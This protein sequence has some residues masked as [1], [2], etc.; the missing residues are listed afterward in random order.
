MIVAVIP[1]KRHSNRLA[2]KNL[3]EIDELPL[4]THAIRY[5]GRFKSVNKIVVSTDSEKVAEIAR[6]NGAMIHLRGQELSGE[7]PLI[8]VYR[9]VAREI[10]F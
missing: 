1:A 8:E 2:D 4:V 3:L 9:D 5:A 7:A 10:G 6:R